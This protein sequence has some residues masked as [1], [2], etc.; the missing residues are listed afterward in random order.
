MKTNWFDVANDAIRNTEA[1]VVNFLSAIAPWGAP[2]APASMAYI[3]MTTHLEFHRVIA[4]I[5]A[6]VIE[7]LG[8][9]TVHT[10]ITFWQFNRRRLAEYKRRP[11]ELAAGMF[12]FYLLIILTTNVILEIPIA[13]PE[14][15]AYIAA[16]IPMLAKLLLSLLAVP[17]AVTMAIRAN[18]TMMLHEVTGKKIGNIR[19]DSE[20]LEKQEITENSRVDFRRLPD[21]DKA[22]ISNMTTNQVMLQYD[23]KERTARNW[24]K[25]ARNG[26]GK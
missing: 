18:H 9:A 11:T 22:I 8:L 21:E 2:L 13:Y 5:L 14:T 26:V 1:S 7:I 16:G 10:T 23:V 24:R 25:A 17:A 3:G 6:F 20:K 4:G 12:G 15:P 19:Q